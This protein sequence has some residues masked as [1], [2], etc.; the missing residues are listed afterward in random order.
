MSGE[1]GDLK[2]RILLYA[3][4]AMLSM[5]TNV[6]DDGHDTKPG[7]DDTKIRNWEWRNRE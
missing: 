3:V 7:A 2:V 5:F 4:P 6:K 1:L